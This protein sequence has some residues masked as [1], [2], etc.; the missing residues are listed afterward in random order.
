MVGHRRALAL[1]VAL[2]SAPALSGCEP[3]APSVASD[4]GRPASDAA[5]RSDA[6]I[7]RTDAGHCAIDPLP[8]DPHSA[9]RAACSFAAGATP[10][11]SLGIDAA[12]AARLPIDHI[13][14]VMQENRSFDHTFATYEGELIDPLPATFTNP[15]DSG[16][17][18]APFH[19]D[20]HC[21]PHDPPHQ[22]D[23]MHASWNGGAMDGFVRAADDATSDGHY[24][25]GY[26]D[27]QDRPFYDWLAHT[28]AI[29]DRH[30]G[31]ALGGTWSNRAFLYTGSSHGIHSTGELT[32]PDARTVFDQLDEAGV[33]W[34]VF[35]SGNPR[36]DL[37]GWDRTHAGVAS[38]NAFLAHLADGTLP[39]VSFVDPSGAED[40]HPA[41]DIGGGEQW[42]RRIYEGAIASPLWP[43][44]VIFLTY[45]ESGGLFDHVPPPE[46]CLPDATLTEFDRLGIRV[47][48]FVVSPWVRPGRVGHETSSHASILRFVQLRF[49][50][51][52]LSARD[53]NAGALLDFFDFCQPSFPV[54]P[55]SPAA[56]GLEGCP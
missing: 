19:L 29:S 33:S 21:L 28:F 43:S 8:A 9:D 16:T 27:A 18:V 40:E 36:Q 13:V 14:I 46:A 38:F 6:A 11:S 12:L 5:A 35:T 4:A 15:D 3:S 47:P 39:A 42:S 32:I 45:D 53:A 44:L 50:L 52:A 34:G 24:V 56:F 54:G 17:A 7:P 48:L 51:P 30:F 31:D 37:L 26:Y 10:E 41:N 55:A 22:W 23:A 20:S 49:G 1:L 25:M 2:V